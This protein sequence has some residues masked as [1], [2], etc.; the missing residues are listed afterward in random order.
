MERK[1]ALYERHV[2]AGGKI[3]PFAGFLLPVQYPTGVLAEHMA[4]R[5]KAGLFDVSHMGE[6]MFEGEDALA[7]LNHL[8]TNDFTS[9]TDGQV[10]YS[11]MCNEEGGVVDDLVV[12]RFNAEKYMVVV[13]AANREKDAAWMR[14][15]LTGNVKFCEISDELSQL[16]LQGPLSKQ[17][18]AK[19]CREEELPVRYY[20]FTPEMKV[21]G[22]SCLVSKTGYTGEDGYELYM[23]NEKA[24]Q[25]WDALLAAGR[26]EGLIP[27]GLGARD[28]LR[29]EAAMP[30][31]GHEMSDTIDPLTAGLNFAVKM[32]KPEFIGKEAMEHKDLTEKRV[33]LKAVGRGILREEEAV[34]AGN[35]KIGVTT[36]GTFCPFLKEALAMAILEKDYTEPGTRVEVDVR[37]RRI[38]AEVIS[39]PFYK[40]K[41]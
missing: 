3:V 4:V 6:V 26:E 7:A 20:H 37:G 34:Y 32:N 16:A 35:K 14:A 41:Q 30:L 18:L 22:V 15:H 29:L 28:T 8:M 23:A 24:P 27:C 33:G 2:S 13:N 5:T 31:Y 25:I 36:S 9:M 21:D 1:T 11:P 17:I 12:C 40:K 19:I 10:R 39:L 38:E